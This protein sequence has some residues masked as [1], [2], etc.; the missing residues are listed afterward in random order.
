MPGQPSIH[1]RRLRRRIRPARVA[2]RIARQPEGWEPTAMRMLEDYSITWGGAGD[3]LVPA[4]EDGQV[5][6]S[7]WP[8]IELYDAD[9]WGT[10]VGT[11]RGLQLAD[12]NGFKTWLTREARRW[13][14]KYGGGVAEARKLLTADHAMTSDW[15]GWP[16]PDLLAEEL[17]RRTAPVIQSDH[18]LFVRYRADGGVERPLVDVT[19]L[20]PLPARVRLLDTH[21]LPIALQL[22]IAMRFGALAPDHQRRL[23][24]AGTVIETV[25]VE[26]DDVPV[27]LRLA[28]SGLP[29]GFRSLYRSYTRGDAGTPPFMEDDF[30][31]TTPFQLASL[32]CTRMSRGFPHLDDTPVVI[33]VGDHVDDFCYAL[34]LDRC[35]VPAI[36]LPKKVVDVGDDRAEMVLTALATC[37]ED[38]GSRELEHRPTVLRSLSVASEELNTL[39]ERLTSKLGRSRAAPTVTEDVPVPPHRLPALLDPRCFDEDLAEPFS[40]DDMAR[41]VPAAV[42]TAVR[43]ADPWKLTWWVE[44]NDPH[45]SLPARAA[46]NDLVVAESSGWRA[47]ARCGRDG[48]SYFSHASGISSGGAPIEQLVERPRLRFPSATKIFDRLF[49]SAGLKLQESPAGRFRRLTTELWGGLKP[50][51]EDLSD[52]GRLRLLQ[53]W[54]SMAESGA[55][56]GVFTSGQRRFLSLPDAV[57]ASGMSTEQ[58]RA[59]LDTLIS[60]QILRRGFALKCGHCLHFDWYALDEIGQSFT[61]RRCRTSTVVTQS[62]WR[63]GDEPTQYYDLAEVVQQALRGHFEVPVRALAQLK[64]DVSSLE[65]IPEVEVTDEHG[66]IQLEIDLLAIADGRLFIGEAKTADVLQ[67]TKKGELKWLHR[68]AGVATALTTDEVVFATAAG[69]WSPRTSGAIRGVFKGGPTVRLLAGLSDGAEDGQGSDAARNDL[70]EEVAGA[71]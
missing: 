21:R 5:D 13:A 3:L 9:L 68:F 54:L 25:P 14:R 53:A 52:P 27:V 62:V 71:P 23:V 36:W 45:Y 7:L 46:L 51:A 48:I 26:E 38:P 35:G 12:P 37:L 65:Q 22:I 2:T 60:R 69:K 61:C 56:P 47:T 40:S 64:Q 10:Y 41:G 11:A 30:L 63:N 8:L 16:P 1:Y 57:A 32:G 44:V 31:N 70:A 39:A 42:P 4:G 43:S 20:E 67:K 17:R 66:D 59:V 50:L 55:A 18:V 19:D 24:D 29:R 34:A 6:A 28:W 33:V 58:T 15:D 49:M